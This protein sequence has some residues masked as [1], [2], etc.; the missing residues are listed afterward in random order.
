M[1]LYATSA[2]GEHWIY[3]ELGLFEFNGS[4]ANPIAVDPAGE[5]LIHVVRDEADPDPASRYKGLFG[6]AGRR[7]AVSPD[8]FTWTMLEVP[9][10][11]SRDESQFSYDP[12]SRHYS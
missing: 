7:P 4:R 11:P 3:P 8:G 12:M 1:T 2:D 10:V 9:M 5:L 6:V